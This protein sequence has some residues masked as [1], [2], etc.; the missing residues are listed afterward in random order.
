LAKLK[1]CGACGESF[2]CAVPERSCWCE[3][4]K[5]DPKTLAALHERFTDCLCPRCL[6]DVGLH[7]A[8]VREA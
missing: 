7:V 4:V 3:A 8:S 2:E 1:T 6:S 5:L